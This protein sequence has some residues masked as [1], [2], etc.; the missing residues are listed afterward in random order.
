MPSHVRPYAAACPQSA[1]QAGS[2][3]M[4]LRWASCARSSP[5][6]SSPR[7]PR[8]WRSWHKPAQLCQEGPRDGC[9]ARSPRAR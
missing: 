4:E 9:A 3:A 7:Q 6:S 1:A 2:A 8:R 5:A